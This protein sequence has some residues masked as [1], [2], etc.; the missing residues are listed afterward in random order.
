[1]KDVLL[2]RLVSLR[3]QGFDDVMNTLGLEN[4]LCTIT[5]SLTR[6]FRT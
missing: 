4:N 2:G 1:M 3:C 5:P 6:E